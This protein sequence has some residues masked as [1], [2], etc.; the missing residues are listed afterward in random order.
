M[1]SFDVGQGPAQLLEH[2]PQDDFL[3]TRALDTFEKVNRDVPLDGLHWF[4]D[5]AETI[6]NRNIDRIAKE[7]KDGFERLVE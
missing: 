4:I 1:R 2:A 3:I 7:A 5:H 6:D